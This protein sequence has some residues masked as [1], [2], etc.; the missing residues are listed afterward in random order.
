MTSM[1]E[2]IAGTNYLG[3]HSADYSTATIQWLV[4]GNF[5]ILRGGGE[6]VCAPALLF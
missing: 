5:E 3:R 2:A 4:N 1:T 6:F